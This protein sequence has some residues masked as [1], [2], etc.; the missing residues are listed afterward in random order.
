MFLLSMPR[1]L[2]NVRG[3]LRGVCDGWREE[4]RVKGA[5]VGEDGDGAC[6]LWIGWEP[7]DR[8]GAYW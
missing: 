7:M 4:G 5:V 6:H 3:R 2:M 1:T 8:L